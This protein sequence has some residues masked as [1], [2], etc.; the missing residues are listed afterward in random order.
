MSPDNPDYQ[1]A[2]VLAEY[3]LDFFDSFWV[4]SQQMPEL[5]DHKGRA[6]MSWM[7][8]MK[9]SFA[10]S[11]IMCRHLNSIRT[12]YTPEFVEFA[13]DSCPKGLISYAKPASAIA[14]KP[15]AALSP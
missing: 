11:P 9:A 15:L 7:T 5:L 2:L 14:L 1:K 12:W 4:Q 13:R 6:W 10:L 8:Y 3:Q